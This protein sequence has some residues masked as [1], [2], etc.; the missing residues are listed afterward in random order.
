LG[1]RGA[2][3]L[4]TMQQEAEASSQLFDK[5]R[6]NGNHRAAATCAFQ[7]WQYSP[8]CKSVGS[9][10]GQDLFDRVASSDMSLLRH[11]NPHTTTSKLRSQGLRITCYLNCHMHDHPAMGI[12]VPEQMS[13]LKE[14]LPFVQ[15]EMRLERKMMFAKALF[16]P[17]GSRVRTFE[18]FRNDALAAAAFIV[19]CGEPFDSHGVPPSLVLQHKHGGGRQAASEIKR[20]QTTKRKKMAHLKADQIRAT[21]HGTSNSAARAARHEAVEGNRLHAAE[22]RHEHMANM[23]HR[24]AEQE[25]LINTVKMRNAHQRRERTARSQRVAQRRAAQR[26]AASPAR[27]RAVD[28]LTEATATLSFKLEA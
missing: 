16:L 20:E 27:T 12:I 6:S 23:L 13:S 28:Q 7:P 18:Q 14:L 3:L 1:P 15:K 21:G 5:G 4:L 24:A 26:S 2:L 8:S 17:D 9:S 22:L 19:G 10:P 25:S 11:P